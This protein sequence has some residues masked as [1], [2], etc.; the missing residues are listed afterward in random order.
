MSPVERGTDRLRTQDTSNLA[1]MIHRSIPILA[2]GSESDPVVSRTHAWIQALGH[3]GCGSGRL[4]VDSTRQPEWG[5]VLPGYTTESI[6]G[7]ETSPSRSR[8]SRAFTLVELLVAISVIAVLIG[9]MLP[10]I[11]RVRATTHRVV[12]SSNVRQIGLGIAMYADDYEGRLPRTIFMGAGANGDDGLLE[13]TRLRLAADSALLTQYDPAGGGSSSVSNRARG[14]WDGL[15]L[16]F[17]GEYLA[18][19]GVFYCP[20]HAGPNRL[21]DVVEES[22][23]SVST[24]LIGNFQYRAQ[25]PDGRDELWDIDPREAVLVSDSLRPEDELNHEDGANTLRADLAVLWF[26]DPEQ[27]LLALS[28][29]GQMPRAWQLLDGHAR[30]SQ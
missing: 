29:A 4:P 7:I 1:V 19:R 3:R 23:S 24:D 2:A 11:S 25:G 8:D 17:S 16:L 13:T 20:S 26:A 28:R 12:C 10:A 21:S 27:N 30:G 6:V 15:G 22:W 5:E 9:L 18:A 14:V